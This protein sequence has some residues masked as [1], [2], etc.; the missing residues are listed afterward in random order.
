MLSGTSDFD[1]AGQELEQGSQRLLGT[2]SL[3]VGKA[4]IDDDDADYGQR[5]RQHSLI[6][7]EIVR[8]Q[9]E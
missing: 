5:K 4:A 1:V 3:P 2:I 7:F 6:G 9:G 8:D